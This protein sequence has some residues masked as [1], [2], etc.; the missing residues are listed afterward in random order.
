MRVFLTG[1]TGV[2]GIR[3]IPLL[4]SGGHQ[5]SAVGRSP[6]SR[7]RLNALGARALELDLFDSAAVTRAIAGHEAVI[8]LATHIPPSLGAMMVPWA[9]RENDR[10]RRTAS[11]ILSRAAQETGARRF[12]QESFAPVYAAG[13]DQ[14]IDETWPVRPVR[15]NRS[16]LDAERSAARFTEAGGTGV[17]LRFAAF[18]GPDDFGRLFIKTVRR[19]WSPLPGRPD[20]YFSSLAQG[21]AA[22]AVVAALGLPVG[23]YNVTDDEPLRRRDYVAVLA[24]A[25][26]VAPP[27]F[28]PAWMVRLLG[29][30]GEVLAR[31]QRISNGKLR[32]AGGWAPRFRSA[33]EGW[34]AVVRELEEAMPPVL[35]DPP[36]R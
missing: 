29:S 31:S 35:P 15:Y 36:S 27:R 1:A 20:G 13:G 18:Y 5:V 34:P 22:T 17:I 8:N 32:M 9:W 23:I 21:D 33:R 4:L 2:V 12:I 11:G 28:A 6:A 10:L 3:A 30:A 26:G 16:V 25:L 14:W 19:G 24:K 7:E